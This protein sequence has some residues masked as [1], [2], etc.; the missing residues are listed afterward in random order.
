MSRHDGSKKEL[1]FMS[2]FKRI[3]EGLY[4]VR[5]V[6]AEGEFSDDVGKVQHC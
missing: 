2:N 6:R 4:D 1:T 5:E 3:V